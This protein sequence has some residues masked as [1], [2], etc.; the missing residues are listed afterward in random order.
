M[1][2]T[3]PHRSEIDRATLARLARARK[4]PVTALLALSRKR[5]PFWMGTPQDW[6]KAEWFAQLWERYRFSTGVHL[7]RIHYQ[8]V[9]QPDQ[10]HYDGTRYRN[11]EKHWDEL[12]TA[13]GFARALR[14]VPVDAFV[15]RRNPEPYIPAL[16]A[17]A[18]LDPYVVFA[19]DDDWRLPAIATDLLACLDWPLP[20]PLVGGYDD[21]LGRQG[22][23]LELWIEKT[24]MND[25]LLPICAELGIVL[26]TGAGFQSTSGAVNLLKRV[27]VRGEPARI[28]YV[29]DFDPSGDA[30]PVSVARQVEYWI[31]EFAPGADVRLE[32]IALTHQ[33][34][35][36]HRLP[37]EPI[38]D[39]DPGA[40]VFAE[41]YG[42]GATELDA[43]EAL[44]PGVLA[45]IVRA[46][47]GPYRD[48]TLS[49]RLARARF[50]AQQLADRAWEAA[51]AE[52]RAELA[53]I[54]EEAAAILN[55]YEPR[56]ADLAGELQR[57]LAPLA[58]R[59]DGVRHAVR[60]AADAFEPDLPEVEAEVDGDLY[61]DWLF[62]GDRDYLLQMS[63]YQARKRGRLADDGKEP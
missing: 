37:R 63:Y 56:L 12:G 18:E 32:P 15:D 34:V 43:L 9:S 21:D 27:A 62:D 11:L 48:T 6:E 47:A 42:V 19:A 25:V 55:R 1:D 7:R 17:T 44:A 61:D 38:K 2:L 54:Q 14:L 40:L 49:R 24:T 28:F 46:A 41:R 3:N 51:T 50:D 10:L 5:D 30:M 36:E 13:S 23:H 52:E 29:S 8:L 26:V 31:D 20:R 16:D 22:F 60:A 58:E 35:V 4:V 33:Q 53:S 59:L 45:A 57:E 39:S